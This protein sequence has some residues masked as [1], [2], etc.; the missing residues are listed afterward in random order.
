M[1]LD[2]FGLSVQKNILKN[3]KVENEHLLIAWNKTVPFVF[4]GCSIICYQKD[5]LP[6]PNNFIVFSTNWNGHISLVVC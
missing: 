3:K 2:F 1:G 4:S 5:F 6:N